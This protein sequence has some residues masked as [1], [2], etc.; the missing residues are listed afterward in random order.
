MPT[1][2]S[3][4]VRVQVGAKASSSSDQP[5]SR[6]LNGHGGCGRVSPHGARRHAV[7]TQVD[8]RGRNS[9]SGCGVW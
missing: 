2:A 4:V 8:R 5:G 7:S 6:P 9:L 3:G 1:L